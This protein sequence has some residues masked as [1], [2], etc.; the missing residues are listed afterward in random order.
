M[1]AYGSP[2]TLPT[3]AICYAGHICCDVMQGDVIGCMLDFSLSPSSVRF[4]VNGADQGMAFPLPEHMKGRSNA[5]FPAV[6]L[7]ALAACVNFGATP[8]RHMPPGYAG[9]SAAP[10]EAVTTGIGPRIPAHALAECGP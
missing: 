4:S 6:T 7:K 9:I 8:F 10:A 1:K 5:L 2:D 3:I